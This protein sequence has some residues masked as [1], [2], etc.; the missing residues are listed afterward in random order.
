MLKKYLVIL[1]LLLGV[2]AGGVLAQEPLPSSTPFVVTPIPFDN[3]AQ[4]LVDITTQTT[5]NAASTLMN[6]VAPLLQPPQSEIGQLILVVGGVLLLIAGWRVY[7]FITVIAGFLVGVLLAVQMIPPD[8]QLLVI[9]GLIIGGVIGAVLAAY[10]FY[11]AVFFIGAYIGIL[12]VNGLAGFMATGAEM[13]PLVLLIAGIIGGVVMIGLSFEFLILLA[14]VVGA[15]MIVLGL[16]MDAGWVI[17]LAII[18]VVVQLF[19]TRRFQYEIRRRP[20]RMNPF[21]RG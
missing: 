12:I 19:L 7:E 13:P 6:F 2:M 21:R 18:G 3:T 20:T 8:N 15:Q 16:G 10:L 11:I 9:I 14:A 17:V 4:G 1:V 5:E